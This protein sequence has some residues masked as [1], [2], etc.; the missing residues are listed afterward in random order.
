MQGTIPKKDIYYMLIAYAADD[1]NIIWKIKMSSQR[2]IQKLNTGNDNIE[3]VQEF[4]YLSSKVN[5]NNDTIHMI[6]NRILK[7]NSCVRLTIGLATVQ[8]KTNNI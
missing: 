8:L 2:E 1:I 4:N 7:G 3:V 6:R 5:N